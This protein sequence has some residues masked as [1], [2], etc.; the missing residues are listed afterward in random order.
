MHA[1]ASVYIQN[2]DFDHPSFGCIE[3]TVL[4]EVH[5]IVNIV[6]SKII[7][8]STHLCLSSSALQFVHLNSEGPALCFSSQ[9]TVQQLHVDSLKLAMVGIFYA[10]E[11]SKCYISGLFIFQRAGCCTFIG[12]SLHIG[13]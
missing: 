13:F 2:Y 9:L 7:I 6:S 3:F 10:M 11:I 5:N 8:R 1:H 12:I 4:V